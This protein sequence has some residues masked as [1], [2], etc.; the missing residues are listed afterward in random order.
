METK[1][2]RVGIGVFVCKNGKFL[3]GRRKGSHG[4]GDWSIPG[5]HLEFGETFEQ[6]AA[7]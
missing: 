5:G 2:T 6:T 1:I 4:D 7:R 3:M